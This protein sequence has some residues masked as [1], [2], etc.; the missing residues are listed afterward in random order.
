MVSCTSGDPQ[1]TRDL[2][3]D[4]QPGGLL[5]VTGTLVQPQTP[6]ESARLT[7]DAWKSWT[8]RS[9]RSCASR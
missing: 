3:T 2:L 6:G 7:V 5:R 1:I 9:S 8:P 4:I